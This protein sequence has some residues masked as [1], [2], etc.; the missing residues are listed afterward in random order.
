M[1]EMFFRWLRPGHERKD[2]LLEIPSKIKVTLIGWPIISRSLTIKTRR[3][4]H[5]YSI[6]SKL[7]PMYS[8]ELVKLSRTLVKFKYKKK[9]K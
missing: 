6:H 5:C 8:V 1:K 3:E 2:L 7:V 9:S 4:K